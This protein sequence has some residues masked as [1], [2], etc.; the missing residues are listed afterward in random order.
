MRDSYR[1][2]DKFLN[3]GITAFSKRRELIEEITNRINRLGKVTLLE[4]GCGQGRL[5]LDL[6]TQFPSLELHG[7]NASREHGLA[8][9]NDFS[10]RAEEWGMTMPDTAKLPPLHIGSVTSLPLKSASF[11]VIISQVTFMHVEDK[12]RGIEEIIRVLKPNGIALIAIGPYSI[13]RKHGHRMP[14]FY[15]NLRNSIGDDLNPRFLVKDGDRFLPFSEVVQLMQSKT[16]TVALSSVRFTSDT[17]R[18][19]GYWLTIQ[20]KQDGAIA[21][22]LTYHAKDSRQL[23]DRHAG[24]NPVNW[25]VIDLYT[26]RRGRGRHAE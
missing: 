24:L 25:G 14:R 23:T 9:Q 13:R 4:V 21:L 6:L 11:D 7:I 1:K 3:R 12:A 22:P 16:A 19:K 10:K 8:S 18:A 20:K 26:V 17:Q 15:K 5:L 2:S